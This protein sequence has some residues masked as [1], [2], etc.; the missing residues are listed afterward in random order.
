MSTIGARQSRFKVG[1]LAAPA[2]ARLRQC[3]TFGCA[4]AAVAV[5]PAVIASEVPA[6]QANDAQVTT[7]AAAATGPGNRA[8]AKPDSSVTDT[9]PSCPGA[10]ECLQ[11]GTDPL[12]PYGT[13]PLVPYGTWM[14]NSRVPFGS[15]SS[16]YT[17]GA[18]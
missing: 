7:V 10:Y 12:V 14:Q 18:V 13:D 6:S 8:T 3:A 1:A 16:S 5:L 9:S 17:G 4:L 2:K 11:P 15:G